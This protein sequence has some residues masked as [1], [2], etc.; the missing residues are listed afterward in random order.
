MT[1]EELSGIPRY[2]Y[3]SYNFTLR[4]VADGISSGRTRI[5]SYQRPLVWNEEQKEL[6]IDS[7]LRR[8]PIGSIFIHRDANLR[9]MQDEL[10]DGR[11]RLTAFLDFLNNKFSYKG[12]FYR[13]AKQFFDERFGLVIVPTYIVELDDRRAVIEL[14]KRINYGGTPHTVEDLLA[15][16]G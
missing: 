8:L 6:L 5:P 10:L 2:A 13:D 3:S 14:F 1:P 4:D 9:L 12:V 11:Q 7:I 15:L 16:D